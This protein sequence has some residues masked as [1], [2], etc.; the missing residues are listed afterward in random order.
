MVQTPLTAVIDLMDDSVTGTPPARRGRGR[1][2]L[3]PTELQEPTTVQALERGLTLLQLLS[4]CDSASLTDLSLQVGLPAATAYRLLSTLQRLEF[5]SF[6][7][8][9]QQW[10]V[11]IEAFTVG[12]SY[13]NRANLVEASR[14]VMRKLM[15]DTGETANLAILTDAGYV[16][17]L[18]QIESVH[19]IR[20]FHLPGTR[21]HAHSSGIG[22]ALLAEFSREQVEAVLQKTGLKEFTPKTLT[23]PRALFD[24]LQTIYRRGWS[25][26]DEERHLGMRCIGAAIHNTRGEAIAGVSISGPTARF[27][28]EALAV[29]GPKVRQ[30]ALE[31]TRLIGGQ[32][33][34][35]EARRLS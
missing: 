12:S 32:V 27:P 3:Q 26:D 11:G 24:D 20:A 14:E 23:Q 13:F 17:F 22:K 15:N 18:T 21:G 33:P 16:T 19:P 8:A 28:D 29:L 9:T 1:P 35:Y 4:K 5:V 30:A 7:E 34:D 25:V 2:R 31:I 10:A 6:N